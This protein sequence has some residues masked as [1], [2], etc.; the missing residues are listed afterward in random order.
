M[1]PVHFDGK[2]GRLNA[3]G[4]ADRLD[5]QQLSFGVRRMGWIRFWIQVVLG[6]VVVGVL[7]FNN[8]GSSLARNAE[9]AVGL[10][11]GLSLTT[12]AFL[13]LLYSLWQGWLIVRT[14]RAIAS[15][16][17]PSRGETSRLIKRGLIADLGLALAAIGYQALAGRAGFDAD[18]GIAIGGRG[19]AD[20]LA[21]TSSVLSVLGNTRVL[22]AH[23]IG[24]FSLWLLQRIYRTS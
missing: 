21:I 16:A 20:N 2:F 10:G 19:M 18:P 7:L 8:V 14:G 12:L 6:I 23:L 3:Q 15:Q 22:F 11:P 17:R 5:F 9:R 13:V 1:R 4:M 24:L